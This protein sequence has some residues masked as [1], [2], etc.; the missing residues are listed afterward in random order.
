MCFAPQRRTLFRHLNLQKW[1]EPLVLLTFWL[2][3]VLRPTTACTFSTSEPPKVARTCGIFN[4]LTSTCASRHNGMHFFHIGTSKSGASMWC[5]V[6]F[7]F[8]ICFAPQR[9]A[10]FP[11]RN[12]QK[13]SERGVFCTLWLLN[14]LRATTACTFSIWTSKSGASMWCFVHFHFEICFA[15]QRRAFFPHRNFQKWSER[16]VFCTLWLLNVLRA[17][18]ACT[19]SIWTSKSGARLRCFAHFDLQMC[20]APQRRALFRHLNCQKWSAPGVFC[21]F[22]LANV[23][24][25]TT[26]CNFSSLIWPAGSAP[27][28]LASLLFDPPER[29]IIGKTQCFATFLPFRASASAFFWFFLFSDLLSST[30]SLFSLP[31]PCS[32][33][34]LSILSEVWLLNFFRSYFEKSK[35]MVTICYNP[36][37]GNFIQSG[38]NPTT[39][40]EH[41]SMHRP[42][43]E[44][45]RRGTYRNMQ[46]QRIFLNVN[47]LQTD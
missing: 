34:H 17:T 3:N 28:A 22:W 21:T 35:C 37:Y 36:S 19:F 33:F 16:G 44:S 31:L 27:T 14:V 23:L 29:Q 15:P 47:Q 9:R 10:F 13:W 42:S 32:A 12:F 4:I 5:F 39:R 18:T 1:S 11:H 40:S 30:L 46:N 6:H 41:L 24:R 26:A 43:T 8:E 45:I 25:A 7:H 38:K 20:F 2:R